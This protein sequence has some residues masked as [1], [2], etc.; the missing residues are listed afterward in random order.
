MARDDSFLTGITRAFLQGNLSLLLI[1]IALVAGGAA[2]LVTPREE[3][4]QIV[5]PLADV[6]VSY[7]G[8]SAEEVEQM[9]AARL[10]RLLYQIDGVE[11]VYSL[12]RPGAAIVTVRF[13]VG[14]DREAS[15]IKLYNKI[16]QN[17]DKVT[18]GI[19]GW[20]V[21]PIEI[22]DV[23]IV[24]ATLYSARYDTHQLYRIAEEVVDQLHHVSDTA[25]ITIHGGQ[26]RA[27]QVRLNAERLAA[28]RLSALEI[29]GA[30][31][32]SNAQMASGAFAQANETIRVETGPFL[33]DVR[34]VR[35]L[36]IGLHDDRPVYLRD[37][38]EVTDGP[39]EQ[40]TDTRIGFGPA[41]HEHAR[42]SNLKSRQ[43]PP[44]DPLPPPPSEIHNRKSTIQNGT[45]PAVTIAI[46]KKKGSN[47]VRVAREIERRLDALQGDLIPDGVRVR[48][49]RD[50]GATANDKVNDLIL[51][52]VLAMLTVIGLIAVSMS[53]REGLIVALAVPIT[54][55]LTLLF[56]LLAGYTINRVTLFALILALGLL[57]DDPTVAVENIH[58]HLTLRRASRFDAVLNAMR[59]ILSPLVVAT[60]A[61]IVCFLPMFFI[62]G[63]MGP[64]MRPM[65]FN[66]PVAMLMSLFVSI[67]LTP[68]LSA[69]MLQPE[70]AHMADAAPPD[71]RATP[72]ARLYR[73]IVLPLLESRRKSFGLLAAL[74]GLLLFSAVLALT[75]L[76]PLKIL[77]FD[78]KNEFQIVVDMPENTP[79]EATSA[80]VAEIE[81]TLQTVPEV[82][83][84]VSTLGAA[85]PMD[86]NGLVRHYY[87]R[88]GPH[89]ADVRV[90]LL[91]RTERAMDS[92]AIV[93]RL[94]RDFEAIGR[95]TGAMLKLVELP[96]GP[97][98]LSMIVA[99]I[100][101]QPRHHYDELIAAARTVAARL[102][103]EPGVVET[104]V[105][106]ESAQRKMTFLVDREKAGL[107]GIAVEDVVQT[108]RLALSGLMVGVAHI[109]T[110]QNELPI[111]L[112]LPEAQRSDLARLRTL[113]VKGR[114]GHTVQLGEL[115]RFEERLE[116][117]PI[118]HKNLERVVFVTA[119]TAGRGPAYPVLALQAHFKKHPL[120]PGIRAD[121]NGEGEWKIT[122]DVFRD[123]GIA[124]GAAL[125]AIYILL[126]YATASY[127]LP[128][129]V[130]L[131]IPL[132]LIGIMPGFWLLN[133]IA[134]RPVG[135]YGTPV[136]FT[137]TAMIGMIALGGIVVRNAI[138]LLD[139]IA[140]AVARGTP[141]KEAILEAGAVRFRPIFLTAGAAILGAWPITLDPI[142]SGLAWALIFGLFVSTAF[143]LVV[144]PVVYYLIYANRPSRAADIG[145]V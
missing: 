137:A 12:S 33:R 9:V 94:R 76:V 23:P 119:E 27:I 70:A 21:K 38:A 132:T 8:G 82:T 141:L 1:L 28:Y 53:W 24:N 86:F 63:M 11:Y 128:L 142:F 50:Y 140:H 68:W 78:N 88:Q 135:G 125:L 72:L 73:R 85:S 100:Y 40:V 143:T 71:F 126:V 45:Y 98:V 67:A 122:V 133:L 30:L 58:R 49:T 46:A 90:T 89:V 123:L 22:D 138:I 107:N 15:L 134:D 16:F 124:Y 114:T 17:V 136:F 121:W 51:N 102:R 131:A 92:H 139:F 41:A 116:D 7:P 110:E 39:D 93:L 57:V 99:E 60:L 64:Y 65:A 47:A 95:R 62:T 52:L 2:L 87:L 14:Q 109:P 37:V 83:A 13:F 106:V 79:L 32:T 4:P 10:E 81:R 48:L 69:K 115:G 103:A 127:A 3:E 36:M 59:E 112:R 111:V 25:G 43:A 77:P 66:L 104:D 34:E 61:V 56:N 75:G 105:M 91:H 29:A 101:G 5:V 96:P 144:V 31:K 19:A 6:L 97:P 145:P 44:T 55:A 74:V 120:P 118:F 42:F 129:I 35:N 80:A 20:I 113:V 130:M 108:V 26:R 84:F 54:Y 117:Q 18:P